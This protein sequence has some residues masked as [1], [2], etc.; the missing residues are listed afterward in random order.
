MQS[1]FATFTYSMASQLK[2]HKLIWQD[3][4][5]LSPFQQTKGKQKR[6]SLVFLPSFPTTQASPSHSPSGISSNGLIHFHREDSVPM[7]LLQAQ[8]R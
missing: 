7:L 4:V 1:I 3:F 6:H 2:R 8:T 5:P